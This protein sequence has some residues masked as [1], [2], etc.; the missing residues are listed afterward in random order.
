MYL[1]GAYDLEGFAKKLRHQNAARRSKNIV[2][3]DRLS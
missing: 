1:G 3:V 2:V